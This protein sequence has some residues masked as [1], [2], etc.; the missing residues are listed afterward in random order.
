MKFDYDPAKDAINRRK[1]G[2]S[3]GDA[4]FADWDREMSFIDNRNDYGESRVQAMV[5]LNDR[6]HVCVFTDRGDV[7]RVIS[8]RKANRREIK[9]YLGE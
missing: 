8:F 9:I 6:L 7:R 3:L 5:P 4:A 2:I 1:H